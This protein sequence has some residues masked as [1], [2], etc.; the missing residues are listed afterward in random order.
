MFAF[1][2]DFLLESADVNSMVLDVLSELGRY[3]N[4]QDISYFYG[5]R[6]EHDRIS[7]ASLINFNFRILSFK[8]NT[9]LF[10]I[11]LGNSTF[12]FDLLHQISAR[13][14]FS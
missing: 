9:L 4:A 8:I 2:T 14:S 5:N 13:I 7:L 3:S 11:R 10:C 1:Y 12:S 6:K